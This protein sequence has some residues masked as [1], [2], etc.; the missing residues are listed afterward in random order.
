MFNR[1]AILVFLVTILLTLLCLKFW[2]MLAHAGNGFDLSKTSIP[3]EEILPG[4]PP[5]DGI[6]SIDDPK[7][8]PAQQVGGMRAEE[9]VLSLTIDGR[10]RAYP[11]SILNWH[12][13]VNDEIAG[14]PVVISYC[15]LCGTGM[16][17]SAEVEGKVLDFGVSGLLYNS[18]VLL[19]DRETESLWSQLKKE[20]VSGPQIGTQLEMLPLVQMTWSEWKRRYPMGEVLS[21]D[22][23]YRRNYDMSPYG[24]YDES[25][26]IYFPVEF[27]S[28]AYHPKE[29]VIGV[30]IDGHYKAYPFAELARFGGD[31]VI[32]QVNGVKLK[33]RYNTMA[34][35]AEVF[36]AQSGEVIPAVNGF[37]FA[38]FTFHPKTDVYKS[39]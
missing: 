28:Q 10:T 39:P 21:R 20:A 22:T 15:P 27:L 2:P 36:D 3:Q 35:T 34:R 18:D 6:P 1:T 16:A 30:D 11:I 23:G 19:Y 29:R 26:M 14:Q 9:Q 25:P 37:W 4:G 7:F 31:E 32:D 38:W 33:I 5:R 13:I 24:S 8:I 12:E 17:F